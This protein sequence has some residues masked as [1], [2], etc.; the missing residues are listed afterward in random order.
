M[1]EDSICVLCNHKVS[2]TKKFLKDY[3]CE[4]RYFELESKLKKLD[5]E[6]EEFPSESFHR[7]ILEK[8]IDL[9]EEYFEEKFKK[10]LHEL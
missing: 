10:R 6:V 1:R 4:Q 5:R 7:I 9:Y 2:D 3:K 8:K